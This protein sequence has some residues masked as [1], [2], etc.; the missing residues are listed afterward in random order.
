MEKRNIKISFPKVMKMGRCQNPVNEYFINANGDVD[1]YQ[2]HED[3]S[4]YLTRRN[5]T[6]EH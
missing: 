3:D 1:I 5:Q 4:D 2:P 6:P